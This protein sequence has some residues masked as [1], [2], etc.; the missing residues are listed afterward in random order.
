M[1]TLHGIAGVVGVTGLALF[2]GSHAMSGDAGPIAIGLAVAGVAAIVWELH[3]VPGHAVPG[4]VGVA[5][6]LLGAL[7]AFGLPFFI[8]A[9]ETLATA[10]VIAAIVYSM[11]LKKLPENAWARRLALSATQGP[12]YVTSAD[13]TSLRGKNRH[14]R[15]VLAPRR[16]RVGGW[17][18]GRRFDRR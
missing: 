13:L 12:D 16:N 17:T 14:R 9:V 4:I 2:F 7:L 1:Q 5:C 6:L 3:V 15:V 8:V 18:P 10:I 11:L